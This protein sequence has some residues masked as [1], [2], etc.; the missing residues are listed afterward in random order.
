MVAT[1]YLRYLSNDYCVFFLLKT[2]HIN[3]WVL[4]FKNRFTYIFY[5]ILLLLWGINKV[6]IVISRMRLFKLKFL[7]MQNWC[8][9]GCMSQ[10]QEIPYSAHP[11][12][13]LCTVE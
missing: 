8:I 9:C 1:I 10:Q 3:L 7:H 6:G 11:F 12:H 2:L 4:F 5:L 13:T